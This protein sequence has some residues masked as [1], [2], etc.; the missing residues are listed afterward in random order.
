MK[1]TILLLA[2]GLACIFNANA[3][4]SSAPTYHI[5]KVRLKEGLNTVKL[6]LN[7]GTMKITL[8]NGAIVSML[9]YDAAGKQYKL[10]VNPDASRNYCN[11]GFDPSLFHSGGDINAE[12]C[13]ECGLPSGDEDPRPLPDDSFKDFDIALCTSNCPDEW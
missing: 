5:Q 2:F 11:C 6:D 4:T 3:Q 12:A 13:G 1:K 9:R 8:R 10:P 7:K